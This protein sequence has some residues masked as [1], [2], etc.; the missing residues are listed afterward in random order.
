M[1]IV[2]VGFVIP[3][4][5][6][7]I[8]HPISIFG[9]TNYKTPRL[10]T[11]QKITSNTVDMSKTQPNNSLKVIASPTNNLEDVA[12]NEVFLH[13]TTYQNLGSPA[14][15]EIGRNIFA[16]KPHS[17]N[18][19]VEENAVAVNKLQR[20]SA[21]V[22]PFEFVPIKIFKPTITPNFYIAN[23]TIEVGFMNP[24]VV[25]DELTIDGK[26]LIE[27]IQ[28]SFSDQIFRKDQKFLVCYLNQFLKCTVKNIESANEKLLSGEDITEADEK[29]EK[30]TISAVEGLTFNRTGF[31]LEKSKDSLIKLIN[32]PTVGGGGA[33]IMETNFESV[34]IGGLDKEFIQLFRRAFASRIFP[35]DITEK[36]GI[37]HV[38]GIMLFGPPGTGKTLIARQIGKM[39]KCKDPKIVNGP[40]VLNKY[41][42]QSEENIR[43]LF[44]DA[45]KEFKEKGES[46]QVHLI[47]FD[48]I[49]AICK[50]R[51]TVKSG[52]GVNDSV[53][54]Q[55][56]SK[57]DGVE[58][59]NNVLIIGMTNRLDMI[60]EALLR[61]GRF[62]VQIEI[63]LPDEP[64]RLQILKIHTKHMKD[65]HMLGED[66]KLE[67]LAV[68]TKNFSGAEIEGLVRSATSFALSRVV[69]I[70]NIQKSM[71]D[72]PKNL[73]GLMVK[74]SDFEKALNEVKPAF[75]VS[76]DELDSYQTQTLIEYGPNY[77]RLMNTCLT[78][79]KQVQHSSTTQLLSVLLDGEIGA[80]K[81]SIAANLA[82]LSQ[83][84][85]I[86]VISAEKMVGYDERSKCDHITKVFNDAYKS[87]LS[88]VILDNIERLIELVNMNG[89]ARFS[90]A[91]LQTL[92]VLIRKKPP[93]NRKL[94][95]VGTTNLRDVLKDLE[96]VGC[97]T[98]S[99]NVPLISASE[100][101]KTV[102][103]K[104]GAF[105]DG[106]ILEQAI[107]EMPSKIG[108]K[109]ILLVV[110]MARSREDK[111]DSVITLDVFKDCLNDMGLE[112]F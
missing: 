7:L 67:E 110:E 26:H 112:E 75:G 38:K 106:P 81:T 2:T 68:E 31:N 79:I 52:T 4:I 69:D 6:I 27:Y 25:V 1:V 83:Y 102:L 73:K 43:L 85:F 20:E 51:G 101:K 91:L 3:T 17:K 88:F 18:N 41:V 63:S 105:T 95:I 10:R 29:D 16:C 104:S 111:P 24:K 5:T 78:F 53:V 62:E 82:I 96:L 32:V 76:T 66:V 11:N 36:L 59:L 86:K 80:G 108:I 22:S 92:L 14:Y 37:K 50:T 45:E 56:L 74:R 46:S 13:P 23:M 40:E 71:K 42:G 70:K 93:K 34:G 60:D 61:P 87:P 19:A 9:S 100:D 47:I 64:G 21:M 107:L 77:K 44:G 89:G 49:D 97:F 72:M 65:A 103:L 15:L 8:G 90:N 33:L 99:L 57:M 12:T 94:L 98:A 109:Q 84:P 35:T 28:K 58:A 54:N 55:L 39:L 30:F 48:E